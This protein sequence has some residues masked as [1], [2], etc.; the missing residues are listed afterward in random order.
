[1]GLLWPKETFMDVGVGVVEEEFV[2]VFVLAF[3][4]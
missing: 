2:F 1:M 3:V 4:D